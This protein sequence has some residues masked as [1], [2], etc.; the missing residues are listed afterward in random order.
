MFMD[1]TVDG[2]SSSELSSDVGV[3]SGGGGDAEGC[4]CE[5]GSNG[6]PPAGSLVM[7]LA[8]LSLLLRRRR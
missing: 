8:V 4:D 6:L 2:G 5:S 7:V 3:G 1:A